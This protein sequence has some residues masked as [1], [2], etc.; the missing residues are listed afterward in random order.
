MPVVPPPLVGAVRFD[1]PEMAC[2]H[3]AGHAYVAHSVGAKVVSMHLYVE[4]PRAHGRTR[5]D[6][7]EDQLQVIALGGFAIERRLW[8]EGRWL[9]ADGRV[10]TEKEH[11]DCS[12]GNATVDKVSYFGG[13]YLQPEG[14][15]PKAMDFEFMTSGQKLGRRLYL[16]TIEQLAG[17]L[18]VENEL[19]TE[20][21]A[22]I[23][24][25]LSTIRV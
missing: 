15:W 1:S 13:N 25:P 11:L 23:L 8:E 24:G 17:I 10:A 16:P 12:S 22:E 18:L 2:M 14:T 19:Q 6:R 9:L 5:V 4:Q 7:T 3:E 21:I 20:R